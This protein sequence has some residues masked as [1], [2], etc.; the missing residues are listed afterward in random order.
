MSQPEATARA[1][2]RWVR[3]TGL[4]VRADDARIGR[5]WFRRRSSSAIAAGVSGSRRCSTSSSHGGRGRRPLLS[6][7]RRLSVEEMGG[8]AAIAATAAV[9]IARRRDSSKLPRRWASAPVFDAELGF[10][11]PL[12]PDFG[13]GARSSTKSAPV[14][15]QSFFRLGDAKMPTQSMQQ[16]L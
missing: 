11:Q 1:V 16:T 14:E 15:T 4:L 12:S 6:A 2:L 7:T 10:A 13:A 3:M 8:A 5:P 9:T